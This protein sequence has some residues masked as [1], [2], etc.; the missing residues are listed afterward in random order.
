MT[1]KDE[2]QNTFHRA[3][4]LREEGAYEQAAGLF[5]SLLTEE[6]DGQTRVAAYIQLG[7]IYTFCLSLPAKGESYF[8]A[9]T[10]L[11]PSYDVPSLGLFHALA[12]QG[13][14]MEAI[15]EMKRYMSKYSSD[16][17]VQ[18]VREMKFDFKWFN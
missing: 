9:A 10:E 7:H 2:V 17:Y 16:E 3:M 5:E 8:R 4:Q 11:V 6:T 15:D 1:E 13:R 12:G 18:L 14:H